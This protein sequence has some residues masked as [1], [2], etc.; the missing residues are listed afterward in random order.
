MTQVSSANTYIQEGG[1]LRTEPGYPTPTANHLST[2]FFSK[3]G[4]LSQLA[5]NG[6]GFWD[7]ITFPNRV[8]Q[9][10]NKG[11]TTDPQWMRIWA[12][13]ECDLLIDGVTTDGTTTVTAPAAAGTTPTAFEAEYPTLMA[14]L[15]RQGL[16]LDGRA[17]RD[18]DILIADERYAGSARGR[19]RGRFG[20]DRQDRGGWISR[21]PDR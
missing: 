18:H 16:R 17:A 8:P 11:N 19:Y 14:G 15:G 12:S 7:T 2:T 21:D 9:D 10:Y 13:K 6:M 5:T 20:A 4:E 1:F 3:T